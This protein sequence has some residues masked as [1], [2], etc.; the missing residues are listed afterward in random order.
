MKTR[1]LIAV[2]VACWGVTGAA[3]PAPFDGVDGGPVQVAPSDGE[4]SGK[5][6]LKK[7]M[8]ADTILGLVGRPQQISTIQSEAG[9]GEVWVYRRVEQ[10]YAQPA[11][12]T[13]EMVPGFTGVVVQGS[14]IRD[15]SVPSYR[16][17]KVKVI[18][19]T[20]LLMFGGRM[21]AGVQT[22]E[23]ERTYD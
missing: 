4:R 6:T 12:V 20:S 22:R 13:M 3:N 5:P 8:T 15:F 2:V 14:G 10:Q 11:A 19:V 21:V 16:L 23:R 1:F 7:G 9:S 18:Q 17:E